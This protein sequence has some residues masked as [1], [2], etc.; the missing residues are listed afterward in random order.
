M[1]LIEILCSAQPPVAVPG[2]PVHPLSRLG[3]GDQIG[4]LFEG[5]DGWLILF[6]QLLGARSGAE[7]SPTEADTS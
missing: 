1:N 3:D 4:L 5:L 6:H 2:P 7:W